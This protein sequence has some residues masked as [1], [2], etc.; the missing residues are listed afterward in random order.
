MEAPVRALAFD[1]LIIAVDV[2]NPLLG[3]QGATRIYGPQ[4]GLQAAELPH[5]EACLARLAEVTQALTGEQASYRGGAGAAGGLGFGLNVFCGGIFQSGGEVFATLSQLE[6]RIQNADVVVTG[7]GAMDAQTLMGKGVGVIAELAARN[8]KRCLCLAGTVRIDP[9]TVPWPSFR[10]YT[11]VPGIASLDEALAR[12][13]N[14][15]QRLAALIAS[16]LT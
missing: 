5:A 10:S 7:E 6:Q 13:E 2:T 14:C 3:S 9:A 16:K 8:G 4:K 15:L 12:P 11:I 1:E